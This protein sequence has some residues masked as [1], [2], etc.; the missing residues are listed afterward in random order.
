MSICLLV[1]RRVCVCVSWVFFCMM[2]VS[3]VRVTADSAC[4]TTDGYETRRSR[5]R[6][7]IESTALAP[8][9]MKIAHCRPK[10]HC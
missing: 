5:H 3:D 2:V 8:Y 10:L 4:K 6:S 1:C 7:V 9:S